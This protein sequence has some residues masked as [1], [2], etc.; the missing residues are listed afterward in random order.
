MDPITSTIQGMISYTRDDWQNTY[1]SNVIKLLKIFNIKSYADIGANL[2]EVCNILMDSLPAL[3]E[4][5]LFEPQS[6]NFDF[7]QK[8]Y[9]HNL[10]IKCLNYGI[11]YGKTELPLYSREKNIGGYSVINAVETCKLVG[12]TIVLKTLEEADIPVVDFVKIDV[13]G[14]E[15]NI[16]RSSTYL[17]KVKYLDIEFHDDLR[18]IATIQNLCKEFFPDHQIVIC[19]SDNV[20]L[21]KYQQ[22]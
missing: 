22:D 18:N 14:A 10:N 2:G 7:L 16:L 20:F 8:R 11:Y 1:H 13:E 9:N 21:E 12:E 17:K 3:K 15:E 6:D 19:N 5:Y 4:A